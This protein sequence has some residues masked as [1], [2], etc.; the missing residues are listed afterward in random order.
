MLLA[1]AATFDSARTIPQVSNKSISLTHKWGMSDP[2][3]KKRRTGGPPLDQA[4]QNIQTIRACIKA[5]KALAEDFGTEEDTQELR[6]RLH[7][8]M[9][10]QSCFKGF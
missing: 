8:G 5:M 10:G 3:D 6:D 4:G 2:W 7:A 9:Y 1:T